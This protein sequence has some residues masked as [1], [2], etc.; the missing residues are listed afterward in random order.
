MVSTET[1]RDILLPE[2]TTVHE[3]WLPCDSASCRDSRQ[4]AESHEQSLQEAIYQVQQS[5]QEATD[6]GQSERKPNMTDNLCRKRKLAESFIPC[7]NE[8]KW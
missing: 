2:E 3:K 1:A 7:A 6:R 5:R 8:L 4:E